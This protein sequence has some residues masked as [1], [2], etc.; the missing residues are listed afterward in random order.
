MGLFDYTTKEI[1]NK[2]FVGEA[3]HGPALNIQSSTT[4]SRLNAVFD[5]NNSALRVKVSGNTTMHMV[6]CHNFGDVLQGS[7]NI[8]LPWSDSTESPSANSKNYLI[9]PYDMTFVKAQVIQENITQN[10]SL[11]LAIGKRH[12]ASDTV[13][14]TQSQ[15]VTA[16]DDGVVFTYTAAAITGTKT[17]PK[18]QSCYLSLEASAT[19]QG[20]TTDHY[21]TSVW[22][23]DTS[24]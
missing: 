5:E 20:G 11:T 17:V 4:Q 2:V 6:F 10:H 16:S 12:N 24:T 18:G 14:G 9:A 19:A 8:Y 3:P 22:T 7:D 1:L 21:V 13:L 15:S 23:M